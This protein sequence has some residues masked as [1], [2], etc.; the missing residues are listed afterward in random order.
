MIQHDKYI[1]RLWQLPC[2]FYYTTTVIIF[3]QVIRAFIG[4]I[5]TS[6][7]QKARKLLNLRAFL[8]FNNL[9]ADRTG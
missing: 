4:S 3:F 7:K 5:P 9:I 8:R 1:A 6:I 2:D